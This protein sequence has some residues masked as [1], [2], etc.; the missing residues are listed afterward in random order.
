VAAVQS[1]FI[2]VATAGVVLRVGCRRKEL[3]SK[4]TMIDLAGSERASKSGAS[5][6]RLEEV[7]RINL[8]LSALGMVGVLP[9]ACARAGTRAC[10]C[11][12]VRRECDPRAHRSEARARPVPRLEAHT[13][14]AGLARRQLQD[15]TP[16]VRRALQVLL[17]VL[18]RR[19]KPA[20]CFGVA[21]CESCKSGRVRHALSRALAG[22]MQP[23]VHRPYSLRSVP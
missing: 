9:S 6:M 18:L 19:C 1:S 22:S 16:R 15:R 5:G 23:R 21:P 3:R 13:T 17:R 4:L 10:A 2:L 7:K 8:S 14:P 12:G 11:A 20:V